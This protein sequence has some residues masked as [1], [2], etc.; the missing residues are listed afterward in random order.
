MIWN[1]ITEDHVDGRHV[2]RIITAKD[3]SDRHHVTD[4]TVI[5]Q[6]LEDLGPTRNLN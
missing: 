4:I 5:Q 3:H 1:F 6:Q 2:T